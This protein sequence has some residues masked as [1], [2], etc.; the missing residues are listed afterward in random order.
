LEISNKNGGFHRTLKAFDFEYHVHADVR[1]LSPTAAPTRGGSLVR[2]YGEHLAG[3]G[4]VCGFGDAAPVTAYAVSSAILV[5]ETPGHPVGVVVAEVSV[6]DEGR[7]FTSSGVLFEFE[8]APAVRAV[9]PAA[10]PLEGG[11]V[12]TV[13]VDLVNH[14][15]MGCKFGSIAPVHARE[16]DNVMQCVSPT[17]AAGAV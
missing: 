1:A 7:V 9:E 6:S 17:H 13:H 12:V 4:P 5:C 14:K 8:H 15:L 3:A 11:T 2:V 10:G 16:V